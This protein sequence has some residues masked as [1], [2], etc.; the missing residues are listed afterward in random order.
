MPY[1]PS[2]YTLGP[3]PGAPDGVLACFNDSDP[4]DSVPVQYQSFPGA[5]HGG[6]VYAAHGG[7]INA[8]IGNLMSRERAYTYPDGTRM[9][10]KVSQGR[11]PLGKR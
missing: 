7:S 8:G 6:A 3:V 4:N 2:G 9:V 5:A 11:M 10:E 1:C